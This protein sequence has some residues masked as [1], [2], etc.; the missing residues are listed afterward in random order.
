MASPL[1][2]ILGVRGAVP[3][4]CASQRIPSAVAHLLKYSRG[5]SR[6]PEPTLSRPRTYLP[7]STLAGVFSELVCIYRGIPH[8]RKMFRFSYPMPNAL[9]FAVDSESVINVLC[10]VI[11][12]GYFFGLPVVREW[13]PRARNV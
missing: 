3:R 11:A 6:R 9:N 2:Q 12:F 4:R 7:R 1:V 10:G 8:A 13:V 5:P